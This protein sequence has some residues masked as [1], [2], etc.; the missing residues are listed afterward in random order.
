MTSYLTLFAVFFFL[1]PHLYGDGG[2]D[3]ALRDVARPE[4]SCTVEKGLGRERVK[5]AEEGCS[6]GMAA[7][8]ASAADAYLLRRFGLNDDEHAR[9]LLEQACASGRGCQTLAAIYRQGKGGAANQSRAD[10]L[11]AKDAALY[12]SECESGVPERCVALAEMIDARTAR[13]Q[14]QSPQELRDKA[15]RMYEANCGKGDGEACVSLALVLREQGAGAAEVNTLLDK[16]CVAG[17]ARG[18]YFR[19]FQAMGDRRSKTKRRQAVGYF[20]KACELG[21]A[22]ACAY[23]A[24]A[25]ERGEDITADSRKAL[26]LFEKGCE[27]GIAAAC[28][29]ASRVMS[30]AGPLRDV[31]KAQRLLEEVCS[32]GEVEGC[33]ELKRLRSQ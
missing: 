2:Q 3:V 21:E 30:R 9:R 19:A 22:R 33:A 25:F 27:A 4:Q 15:R 5:V 7:C 6:R 26:A 24:E 17:V 20:D 14:L 1:A 11:D 32:S 10:E 29:G 31:Q 18:C 8:C 12:A 13:P 16:A 28:V 23:A